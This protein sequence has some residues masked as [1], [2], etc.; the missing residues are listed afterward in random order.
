[1]G[2]A[3]KGSQYEFCYNMAP[4]RKISSNEIIYSSIEH[5]ILGLVFVVLSYS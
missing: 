3:N 1:M 2:L 4:L 5:F